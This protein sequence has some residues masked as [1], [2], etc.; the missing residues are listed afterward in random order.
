MLKIEIPDTEAFN[1]ETNEFLVVKGKSIALEHSLVSV[2]KWE[3]KWHVP[4][5]SDKPKTTE[6]LYDYIRCMTLTQN[7]DPH[8]YMCIPR[9]E[10]ERI[11]AYIENKMT[12][13]WFS[14][15]KNKKKSRSGEVI[16]SE[17]I[18]YW[19]ISLGIPMECQKWHLNRLLTL[20]RVCE[21]KNAPKEKMSKRDILARNKALNAA[22]RAKHNTR[23]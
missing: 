21:E 12:A 2:S 13:T 17:V 11:N 3:S 10:M 14:S 15:D 4:Y 5:L 7:V 1:P 22:R 18:Y 6:Q 19:M 9:S 20:I 8:V 16:T 23:G